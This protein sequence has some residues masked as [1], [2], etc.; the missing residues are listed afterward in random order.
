MRSKTYEIMSLCNSTYF[1]VF[2]D[3]EPEGDARFMVSM[4]VPEKMARVRIGY[5]TGAGR[6]WVA[7]FF[8]GKR[9]SMSCKSAKEACQ[10]LADWAIQT[11]SI[12]GILLTKA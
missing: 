10:A 6:A 7:E 1:K 11:S 8:G 5:L 9:P 2:I 4:S 3:A 12:S